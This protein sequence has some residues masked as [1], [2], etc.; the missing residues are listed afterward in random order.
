M[1]VILSYTSFSQ[2]TSKKTVP[3]KRTTLENIYKEIRKCDTL[4]VA[5]DKKT[6][7]LNHLI[8]TN[9]TM[10]SNLEGER[11][12]RLQAEE[13][14]KEVNKDLLK[15]TKK[16]NNGLLF[17]IGGTAFGIILGVLISN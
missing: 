7:N 17:G 5:Y 14:L 16:Q 9:L 13:R 2:S 6:Q 3:V 12:K 4:R 10:F 11:T 8:N 1:L 15:A